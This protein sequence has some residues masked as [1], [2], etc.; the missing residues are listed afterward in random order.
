MLEK[1]ERIDKLICDGYTLKKTE[2]GFV[3]FR[4]SSEKPV[5][6]FGGFKS[7][8]GFS[9]IAFFFPFAVCAQIKEWSYFYINACLFVIIAII[10]GI[11]GYDANTA[12]GIAIGVTYGY[13]FPYLR[14]I[15]KDNGTLE[16]SKGKSILV[17]ILL[18][19][20]SV[21]PSLIIDAFFANV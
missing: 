11:T 6:I 19:M 1:I 7:P 5:N 20:L 10:N 21:I 12:G 3:D 8:A 4:N 13:M 2:Y 16:N 14:K 18:S 9:W 17:G 15:A